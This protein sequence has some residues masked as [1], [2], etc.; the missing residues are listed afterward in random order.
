MRAADPQAAQPP[1]APPDTR[2]ASASSSPAGSRAEPP[3]FKGYTVVTSEAA[4]DPA[5]VGPTVSLV[6]Q[7]GPDRDVVLAAVRRA[8][9][10]L[11]RLAPDHEILVVGSAEDRETARA[12]SAES[13]QNARV[14]WLPCPTPQDPGAVLHLGARTARFAL[15]A[16][17]QVCVDCGSLDYLVPLAV[18]Y[19]IVCGYALDRSGSAVRR[20]GS[21]I[22][23]ALARVLLGTRVRDCDGGLLVFRRSALA[24]VMPET[25]GPFAA[26]EALARARR[27][28]LPVAEVPVLQTGQ[29][30]P[31]IAPHWR[32]VPASCAAF[33]R[34]WWSRVQFPGGM[35]AAP[36]PRSWVLGG[37]LLVLAA[38]LLFPGLNQPLQDPDEGRQ[39]EVPREMLARDDLLTP[40]MLGQPY[41]EKPPLQYW[42]TAASYKLFG[43]RPWAA[44]LVP[45]LAAWLTVL[46]TFAWG[47]RALGARPAFLGSLGLCLSLGFLVLGRT[48][49]LDSLLTACV[50]AS[51]YAA[52]TALA[53]PY[54]RWTWWLI[55]AGAC[56][57][58]FLAKGPVALIL[59]VVPVAGYQFLA[60][61]APAPDPLIRGG[62]GRAQ[63]PSRRDWL[64]FVALAAGVAA[65]WYVAMALTEPGYLYHFLWKN[66]VLRFTQAYDHQQ[67]WWYYLPILFAGTLPWSFLWAWLVYFLTSRSRRLAE[68][69]TSGL[70]FCVLAAGWCLVFFSASGCKSPFYPAAALAPLAL[71][72][73]ACLDAILF[74]RVGRRDQFLGYARQVL[75]W[76]ATVVVL[77]LSAGCYVATGVLRWEAWRVVAVEAGLTLGALAAWWRYGKRAP[78]PWAWGACAAATLFMVTVAARDLIVGF[79]ARHSVQAIAKTARRTPGEDSCPV[80]SYGR[81]WPSASFYLRREVVAFFDQGRLDHLVAF[82]QVQPEVIVLVEEGP[83][84]DALLKA[85]PAGLE[86]QVKKPERVGQ[87]ALV[88]VRHAAPGRAPSHP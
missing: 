42:L 8:D 47:R 30:R 32:D 25:E 73:G 70:G 19:P 41:Y 10:V 16:I 50:V 58:G 14:R 27:F 82:C 28:G 81:Q 69:R 9:D 37:L 72:H 77:L 76:R 38:L 39:A 87:A 83:L 80:V 56:G 48:V 86:T 67:P 11:G 59:A 45:A 13:T 3:A 43:V 40:R 44:R 5:P 31:A 22:F 2:G 66:N 46:F 33:L 20:L 49:V 62:G 34:C 12:V 65:P 4:Q 36:R 75:P 64:G 78:A 88:V 24:A 7:A 52:H 18:R 85:L 35:P 74:R 23:N 15:V 68:L 26:A 6:L 71:L 57:L 54:F 21:W 63:G 60:G 29:P 61:L 17:A 84:L 53:G 1:C 51:W 55:S 79:A